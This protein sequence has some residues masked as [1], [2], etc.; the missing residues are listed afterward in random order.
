MVSTFNTC[1]NI[2]TTY[3]TVPPTQVSSQEKALKKL[4]EGLFDVIPAG[5][6]D[7]LTAEDFR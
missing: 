3:I 7:T 5:A 1:F 4:R 2:Y 6:L